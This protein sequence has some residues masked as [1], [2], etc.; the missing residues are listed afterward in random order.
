M[1]Y[2]YSPL[3]R[4]SALLQRVRGFPQ[5]DRFEAIGARP[6]DLSPFQRI[7]YCS[8]AL[9]QGALPDAETLEFVAVAFNKYVIQKDE[10]EPEKEKLSLD[11]AF[12]LKS[13]AGVGNPAKQYAHDNK[14]MGLLFDMSVLRIENPDMS[15]EKAAEIVQRGDE[16]INVESLVRRYSDQANPAKELAQLYVQRGAKK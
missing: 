5:Q 4:L 14:V 13:K 3:D 15:L 1:S 16:S 9:L 2:Y 8:Q 10:E 7:Q 11:K 12:G 6:T